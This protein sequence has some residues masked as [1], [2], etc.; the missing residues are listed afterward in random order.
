LTIVAVA[1]FAIDFPTA[2]FSGVLATACFGAVF[3]CATALLFAGTTFT[4]AAGL[5]PFATTRF[6]TTAGRATAFAP[7]L[8][9][10]LAT[11]GAGELTGLPE[12][13]PV[14]SL[15]TLPPSSLIQIRIRG[16]I[17]R[18][19]GVVAWIRRDTNQTR[20]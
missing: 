13:L 5:G 12:A 9:T 1:G 2:G 10:A 11:T 8:A 19:F 20:K 14:V 3:F 15:P 18:N 4:G 7:A 17:C 16:D 6:C